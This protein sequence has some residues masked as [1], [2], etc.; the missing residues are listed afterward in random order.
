[1][2][3]DFEKIANLLAERAVSVKRANNS[4]LS[5]ESIGTGLAGAGLGALLGATSRKNK[6]RNALVYGLGGGLAGVG[7]GAAMRSANQQAAAANAAATQKVQAAAQAA[8]AAQ[9]KETQPTWSNFLTG[10][11]NPSNP[12][13]Y[14][15]YRRTLS[16]YISPWNKDNTGAQGKDR[17]AIDDALKWGTRGS[18]AAGAGLGTAAAGIVAPGATIGAAGRL[19]VGAG[20][21][22]G[23]KSLAD[24]IA[25]AARLNAAR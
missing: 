4:L 16:R 19:G 18:F 3:A 15:D 2:S 8:A 10:T 25:E 13:A 9:P 11:Y 7:A 6:L 23:G 14:E 24:A 22:A 12:T 21:A 1:M 17:G 5:N 20:L